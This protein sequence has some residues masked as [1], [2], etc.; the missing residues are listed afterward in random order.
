MEKVGRR[1]LKFVHKLQKKNQDIVQ[2]REN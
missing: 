2:K 1:M